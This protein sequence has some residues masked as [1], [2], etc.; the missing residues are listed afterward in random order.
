MSKND[1]KDDVVKKLAMLLTNAKTEHLRAI[2]ILVQVE[3]SR[4]DALSFAEDMKNE[5]NDH[6]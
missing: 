2:S 5:G 3:I 1:D 4:R 6:A